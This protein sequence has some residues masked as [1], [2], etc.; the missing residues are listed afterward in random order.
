[1]EVHACR[2]PCGA[3]QT[4]DVRSGW[5]TRVVTLPAGGD[6]WEL[7][8]DLSSHPQYRGTITGLRVD[9]PGTDG[10]FGIDYVY[11]AAARGQFI[12]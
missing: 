5:F 1:M 4:H 7:V 6:S 10:A 2:C 11:V 12:R 9:P 8:A 3:V